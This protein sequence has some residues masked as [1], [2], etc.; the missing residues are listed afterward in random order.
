MPGIVRFVA[1]AG[2]LGMLSGCYGVPTTDQPVT[3][4]P[5]AAAPAQVAAPNGYV[6]GTPVVAIGYQCYAGAYICNLPAPGPIGTGCSCPGLG[7]PSF[8]VVR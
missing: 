5:Y 8:G 6:G 3:S 7:A 2:L 1:G 4:T